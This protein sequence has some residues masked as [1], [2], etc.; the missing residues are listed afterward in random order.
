[1]DA[2]TTP[3]V[4]PSKTVLP[5]AG[6]PQNAS[7]PIKL[8]SAQRSNRVILW[9][10]NA[11]DLLCVDWTRLISLQDRNICRAMRMGQRH[12]LLGLVTGFSNRR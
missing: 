1:M 5:G 3:A 9:G 2:S 4:S 11:Q 12:D 6:S 8:E 7:M 10:P